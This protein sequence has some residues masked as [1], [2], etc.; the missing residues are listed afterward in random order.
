MKIKWTNFDKTEAIITKGWRNK[1][2][3][4]VCR[5]YTYGWSYKN[6]GRCVSIWLD[7]RLSWAREAAIRRDIKLKEWVGVAETVDLPRAP[8][9][10]S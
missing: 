3:A 9:L 8:V 6:T 1:R 5:D 10:S 7:M 4:E 2:Q